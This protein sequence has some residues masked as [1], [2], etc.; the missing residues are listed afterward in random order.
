MRNL[1]FFYKL[2]SDISRL[3]DNKLAKK[4][5]DDKL[6]VGLV[7]VV[8]GIVLCVV[9]KDSVVTTVTKAIQGLTTK[10]DTLMA[11]APTP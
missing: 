1:V 4:L 3:R 5:G 9:Y 2:R 11:D 10:I 7:L 8:I 6:I